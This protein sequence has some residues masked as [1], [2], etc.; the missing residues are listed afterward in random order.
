M[1]DASRFFPVG[2]NPVNPNSVRAWKHGHAKTPLQYT[3]EYRSW[4]AM[5]ARCFD[6]NNVKFPNYGGRGIEVCIQWLDFKNFISDMG[7]KPTARHQ[8]ER[9]NT[10]GNYEPSNCRWATRLEQANNTRRNRMLSFAGFTLTMS[11][12]ARQ[13]GVS[14]YALRSRMQNGWSVSDALT[15]PF[16]TGR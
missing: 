9:I 2:P 5:K 6:R 16:N 12:W 15:R 7:M 13:L 8:L 11:E 4:Q 3:S 10:N 14:Y 1:K